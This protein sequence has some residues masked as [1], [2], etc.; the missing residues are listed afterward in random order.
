[1]F[2]HDLVKERLEFILSIFETPPLGFD[3]TKT[4]I[5]PMRDIQLAINLN[6]LTGS[7]AMDT[8]YNRFIA[9]SEPTV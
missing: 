9:G 4:P 1:M 8:G 3:R 5:L 2:F 7:H 6:N